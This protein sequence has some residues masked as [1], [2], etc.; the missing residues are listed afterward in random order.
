M[1]R[2]IRWLLRRALTIP[3]TEVSGA[4]R[5]FR[6]C[7]ASVRVRLDGIGQL[8][9][10]GHH[11]ALSARDAPELALRLEGTD[12]VD[13]GFAYE[14]AALGLVLL[15]AL[16]CAGL[17]RWRD[18]HDRQAGPHTY[19]VHV[20]AGLALARLRRKLTLPVN[21]ADPLLGALVADGYGFHEGYF[22]TARALQAPRAPARV[23]GYAARAYDQ[24][25]GR[26]L[27][28]VHATDPDGIASTIR[29]FAPERQGDLWSGVGLACAYAGGLERP[30]I[31]CLRALAA[32]H[33]PDLAQGAAFAAEARARAANPASHTRLSCEVLCGCDDTAAA[34]VART[35]RAN[36][37]NA[38]DGTAYEEWR[39]RLRL[40]LARQ[41]VHS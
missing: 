7:E 32:T 26:S 40:A 10:D 36:L 11:A 24:G 34:H 8:V 33:A 1:P 27:W 17:R 31:E 2:P 38:P 19:M 29:T 12:N 22:A 25:L 5:G 39:R 9:L 6:A 21:G 41:V 20:G 35:T 23:T 14:G 28:F 30:G 13:R 37:P 4:R 3:P 16:T 18:F 15:D